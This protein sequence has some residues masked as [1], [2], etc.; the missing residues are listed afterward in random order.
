VLAHRVVI[1][2]ESDVAG[3]KPEDVIERILLDVAPPA[4]RAA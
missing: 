3:V 2:A 4:Y 1:D